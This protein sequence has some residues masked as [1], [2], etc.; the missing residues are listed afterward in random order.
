MNN[1]IRL[2]QFIVLAFGVKEFW[3]AIEYHKQQKKKWVI[4]SVCAGVF[5]CA[6]AIVSMTGIL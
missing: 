1:T 6:C 2:L 3:N 5:A 4:A